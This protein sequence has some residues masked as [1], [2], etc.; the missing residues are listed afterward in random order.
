[1]AT[2]ERPQ[3]D[4]VTIEIDGQAVQAPR[5]SMIIEAADRI[6][7][8]I[9]RF[10]Y[11]HKLSIAANCRMCLVDVEKAPK[12]LPACATP[13]ADGM[14]VF[15]ESKRAVD[16]QR[17]VMEFLL[18]NHPLDCPICDQ[19][20]ECEL[21]DLAMGYGRSISRF[22]ERKRV[23][24]DKNLG[25]LVSTD[26]TRCIH[27]TRCV[28]FLEEIAGTA[29]LGG[30]GR[31]EHTEISTFVERNINSEL[32]GNIIDLCPVGALTNK[33]F[34]FSAR[35]WEMR[36]R[37]FI[38]GHD[39]LGSNLFYHVRGQRIMRAVPRDNEAINECWLADRDRYSHFG[40]TGDDRLTEPMIKV[41]GQWQSCDWDK[42]LNVVREGLGRVIDDKGGEALGML[43]SPRA[44]SEE[45]RL[46]VEMAS[47]LGTRNLDHRLRV[48]DFRHPRAG[49]AHMDIPSRDLAT[50]D[51]IFLV[52][53]NI[54][55]D[56]PLLGHRLRTAWR[57]HGAQIMDLNPV[58]YDFH[59]DLAER[60]T[61]APQAMVEALAGVCRA[62]LELTES[63]LPDGE[64]GKVLAGVEPD[65]A[66]QNIVAALKAAE[67]AVIVLGDGAL[68]HPDGSWLR[69]LASLLASTLEVA[70]CVLPG[71]ANSEGAWLAGCVPGPDG[72]D[73]RAMLDQPRSA[74][75]LWD[76]EPDLDLQDPVLAEQALS[77]SE[78]T[79]AVS[80]VRTA[81]LDTHADVLL[82][83]AA[84][85]ETDGSYVNLDGQRQAFQAVVRPPGQAR[86]GWKIL[87]RLG[88]M[89]QIPGFDFSSLDGVSEPASTADKPEDAWSLEPLAV[90]SGNGTLSR[91]GDTPMYA[92]D[93]L[94]RRSVPLQ[95]TTHADPVLVRLHPSTASD[96]GL[97][98]TDRLRVTQGDAAVDLPWQ[99]DSRIAIGAIWLPG[100]TPETSR[101]GPAWGSIMIEA[102][103]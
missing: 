92:G 50:R 75:L 47:G 74:Y 71:P 3:T 100:S 32:S 53:G 20:G 45:H 58:A 27:C 60:V 31:G 99:V 57:L 83:L 34:R 52:G 33:P 87:R 10:C 42:A 2:V 49:S 61:V 48:S 64:M 46:L 88:A 39:C 102:K 65:Q 81:C 29:E 76:F 84:L 38:G 78:F 23:V 90:H 72:L 28:R 6:G 12:P 95:G 30:I 82:P 35:P 79:V 51:A 4:L 101:L 89:W 21:Q 63:G 103:S 16:A 91:I 86:P 85:L 13:V 67:T 97:G 15:T 26:M 98:E 43:V 68:N 59:F 62:A 14:R 37:P 36:A 44:T 18:I 19:G 22:T 55:H 25:P 41:D 93:G 11:H 80:T 69:A 96:L 8:D 17:G 40:L 1:M 24:K 70:L 54:R 56:Q 7:I 5:G 73:A 94:Q 77:K 9:P 66:S